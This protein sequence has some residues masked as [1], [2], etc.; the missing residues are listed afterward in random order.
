MYDSMCNPGAYQV[1]LFSPS[2]WAQPQARQ[3]IHTDWILCCRWGIFQATRAIAGHLK[4]SCRMVAGVMVAG[5]T[6]AG[7]TDMGR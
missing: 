5:V 4:G 3:H 6:V 2:G 7:C 1:I